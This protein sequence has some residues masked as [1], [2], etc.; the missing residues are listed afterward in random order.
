[1]T[2]KTIEERGDGRAV[3]RNAAL[4]QGADHR[5]EATPGGLDGRG[6][7]AVRSHIAVAVEEIGAGDAHVVKVQAAVVDAVQA[8][9][10][11]VVLA[12]DAG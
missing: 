1:M 4:D 7:A 12:T 2:K 3:Q 11:A 5:E 10:D 8:T 6:V 9:L